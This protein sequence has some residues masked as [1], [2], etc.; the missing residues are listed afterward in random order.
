M[1]TSQI[2]NVPLI[3]ISIFMPVYRSACPETGRLCL[4]PGAVSEEKYWRS[5]GRKRIL[6]YIEG[7][8]TLPFAPT[9][10]LKKVPTF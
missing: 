4:W 9:L 10:C 8:R 2:H 5:P 1:M 6:A 3:I 7:H